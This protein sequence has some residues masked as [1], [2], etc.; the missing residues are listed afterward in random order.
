MPEKR[1]V[2]VVCDRDNAKTRPR[3]NERTTQA[4]EPT[5]VNLF[6]KAADR[7]GTANISSHPT[8]QAKSQQER[9]PITQRNG[10][11]KRSK[12][13]SKQA[14]R[15]QQVN[16]GKDRASQHGPR[17]EPV[18][19][20]PVHLKQ[21]AVKTQEHSARMSRFDLAPIARCSPSSALIQ[22][23]RAT[24][25][26]AVRRIEARCG[27]Q[28][29]KQAHNPRAAREAPNNDETLTRNSRSCPRGCPRC[30]AAAASGTGL[31]VPNHPVRIRTLS[32]TGRPNRR[33]R[34][35]ATRNGQRKRTCEASGAR[36]PHDNGHTT[37]QWKK[38]ES[39]HEAS[40]M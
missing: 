22:P 13:K 33:D 31:H 38:R 40:P 20:V 12:G 9:W 34:Q 5:E 14:N 32:Q 11:K 21:A 23:A 10:K 7:E 35:H 15:E 6:G 30:A 8:A 2:R 19:L 18:R 24:M 29:G 3:A 1:H 4:Q 28:N 25:R 27:S 37:A 17:L 16:H 39:N 36:N 26:K